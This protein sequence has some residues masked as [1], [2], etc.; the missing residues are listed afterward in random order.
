[1][2]CPKVIICQIC[3]RNI[4]PTGDCYGEYHGEISQDMEE[5]DRN[6]LPAGQVLNVVA[7]ILLSVLKV[8][9]LK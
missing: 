7:I 2:M 4:S 5:R 9:S 6:N 8:Y 3:N 1:M